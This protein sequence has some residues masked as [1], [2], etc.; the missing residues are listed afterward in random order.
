M[1]DDLMDIHD[2]EMELRE[3]RRKLDEETLKMFERGLRKAKAFDKKLKDE[4]TQAKTFSKD[5][6]LDRW[7]QRYH[8]H[9]IRV[10]KEQKAR[11]MDEIQYF[12]RN[13]AIFKERIEVSTT[14]ETLEQ[15][16]TDTLYTRNFVTIVGA[17][18]ETKSGKIITQENA[19]LLDKFSTFQ[20][21]FTIETKY[22]K[23]HSAIVRTFDDVADLHRVVKLLV[24]S[25]MR[26]VVRDIKEAYAYFKTHFEVLMDDWWN[27]Q[28]ATVLKEA[29]IAGVTMTALK[30][31][32]DGFMNLH[33]KL[34]IGH[35]AV[36]GAS[37]ATG[38]AIIGVM[39]T[40]Y[41]LTRFYMSG[42]STNFFKN[43]KLLKQRKEHLQRK[44]MEST[45][46]LNNMMFFVALAEARDT[47]KEPINTS[48]SKPTR[49]SRSSNFT[50]RSG[51]RATRIQDL[52]KQTKRK[53]PRSILTTIQWLFSSN[54]ATSQ[55]SDEP[56]DVKNA[57]RE[58]AKFFKQDDADRFFKPIVDVLKVELLKAKVLELQE[59]SQAD[60]PSEITDLQNEIQKLKDIIQKQQKP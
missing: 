35:I 40:G 60:A 50:N 29:A 7:E 5:E 37:I 3:K 52:E 2:E 32:V 36:L 4:I 9:M 44:I 27:K 33:H 12:N 48:Q 11:V 47:V 45:M 41:I 21:V 6:Y 1:Q 28:G 10:R 51:S 22:Q 38:G 30:G 49:R 8:N 59:H 24:P 54:K 16:V 55:D 15:N 23:K 39:V 18:L 56:F 58:I 13:I 20:V 34:V 43:R 19:T 31:A 53:P 57:K 46:F 17:E 14:T 42:A 26:K 25:V